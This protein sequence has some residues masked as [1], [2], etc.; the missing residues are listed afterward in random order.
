LWPADETKEVLYMKERLIALGS[1][2]SLTLAGLVGF[3]AATAPVAQALSVYTLQ[4]QGA[5]SC[6]APSLTEMQNRQV[7]SNCANG[8]IVG[9][10][11]VIIP[12]SVCL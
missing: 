3:Q 10:S 1:S 9:S 5:D 11:A 4:G 2:I 12:G 8:P 6:D 7:D